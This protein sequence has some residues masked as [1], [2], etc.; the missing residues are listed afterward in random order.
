M[1]SPQKFT[2]ILQVKQS[3]PCWPDSGVQ[4]LQP[5]YCTEQ[6]RCTSVKMG[7]RWHINSAYDRHHHPTPSNL[8]SWVTQTNPS[9]LYNSFYFLCF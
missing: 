9:F 2:V 7:G 3:S 8:D 6:N 4:F 1:P 5:I